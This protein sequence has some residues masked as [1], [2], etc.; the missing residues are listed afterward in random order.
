VGKRDISVSSLAVHQGRERTAKAAAEQEI[1]NGTT[2]SIKSNETIPTTVEQ[3]G[4][5]NAHLR[6]NVTDANKHVVKIPIAAYDSW[7]WYTE[8]TG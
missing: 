5:R 8:G 4:N 7:L 2:Q 6:S 1:A 3:G